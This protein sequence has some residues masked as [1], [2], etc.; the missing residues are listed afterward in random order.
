M[1]VTFFIEGNPTGQFTADCYR[2]ERFVEVVRETSYDSAIKVCDEHVTT[3][4]SC[5]TDGI[6]VKPEM[7]VSDEL[8]VNLANTNAVM[9]FSVL[10]IEIDDYDLAGSMAGSE[11]LGHVLMAL[12]TDRDD[13]GVSDVVEAGDGHATMVHCGLPAGYWSDR[14]NAL[15]D[16]AQEASRLRRDVVWS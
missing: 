2:D 5:A 8:D 13:S 1:S 7:D 9:M 10:G 16:L 11:F 4:M 6:Y 12:A 3:C 14:L 15:H